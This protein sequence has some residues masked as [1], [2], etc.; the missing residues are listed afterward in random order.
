MAILR[1]KEISKMNKE[2]LE[3]KLKDL[4]IELMRNNAQRASHQNVAKIK[5]MRR[6]VARL[7]TALR[8]KQT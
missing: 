2:E 7:L 5:E 6:T 8:G 3:N 1:Q 4:R